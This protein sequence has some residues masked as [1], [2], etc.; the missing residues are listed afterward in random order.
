MK[1]TRVGIG[2]VVVLAVLPASFALAAGSGGAGPGSGQSQPS[3]SNLAVTIKS[4]LN[5]ARRTITDTLPSGWWTTPFLWNLTQTKIDNSGGGPTLVCMYG[6]SGSV[7]RLAPSG[8]T[9][10]A[11]TGGFACSK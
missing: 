6:L 11:E 5:L 9:C 4:P 1:A 3:R 10:V 7:Q 8:E 2:F